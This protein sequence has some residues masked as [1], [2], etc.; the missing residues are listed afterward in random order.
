MAKAKFQSM[1]ISDRKTPR[2]SLTY[3][4]NQQKFNIFRET[5]EMDM[6]NYIEKELI[7]FGFTQ[8]QINRVKKGGT[9]NF[10]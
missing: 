6:G 1:S 7:K 10:K 8:S 2:F 3:L 4:K 9:T 5:D